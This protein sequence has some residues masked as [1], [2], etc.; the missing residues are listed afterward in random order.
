[1]LPIWLGTCGAP[2]TVA[3]NVDAVVGVVDTVDVV[4]A[5]VVVGAHCCCC[6]WCCCCCIC[7][8]V[9]VGMAGVV[10]V[11]NEGITETLLVVVVVVVI[12]AAAAVLGVIT[13]DTLVAALLLSCFLPLRRTAGLRRGFTVAVVVVVVVVAVVVTATVGLLLDVGS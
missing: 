13:V 5:N 11:V 7:A 3:A 2:A 6:C 9:G 8:A 1:M 4:C 12:E 10:A